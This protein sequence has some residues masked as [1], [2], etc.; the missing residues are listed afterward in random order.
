MSTKYQ[1]EELDGETR[2]YLLLAKEKQGKG[3]PGI[4]APRSNSWPIIGMLLG[5]GIMILTL[6]VTFPPTDPPVKEAMLQTAG[7]VRLSAS[8]L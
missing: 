2:D 7:F 6:L 8:H 4:F 3:V 5:F 1:F